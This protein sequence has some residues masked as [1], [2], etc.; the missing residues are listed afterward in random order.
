[1][2]L[3]KQETSL[4]NG[5][6]IPPQAVLTPADARRLQAEAKALVSEFQEKLQQT[7]HLFKLKAAKQVAHELPNIAGKLL[8]QFTSEYQKLANET[9]E[10]LRRDLQTAGQETSQALSKQLAEIREGALNGFLAE[11]MA[12]LEK[13]L[14]E[15]AGLLQEQSQALAQNANAALRSVEAAAGEASDRLQ[16]AR[17]QVESSLLSEHKRHLEELAASGRNADAAVRS[18][19]AATAE[20]AAKLQ[21]AREEIESSIVSDH[22]KRLEELAASGRNADTVIRLIEAATAEATAK[23]QSAREQMAAS[24]LADQQKYA[25]ELAVSSGNADTAMRAVQDAS[26]EA[27]AKLWAAGEQMESSLAS[28]YKKRAEELA[29]ASLNDLAHKA[30]ISV[31]GF[32]AQLEGA[33]SAFKRKATARIDEDIAKATAGLLERSAGQL[34]QQTDEVREKLLADLRDSGSGVLEDTRRQLKKIEKATSEILNEAAR[35]AAEKAVSQAARSVEDQAQ[36]AIS[37]SAELAI[38]K[39]TA[40]QKTLQTQAELGV[41]DHQRQLAAVSLA[42]VEGAQRALDKHLEVFWSQLQRQTDE[43]REKLLT[44]LTESGSVVLEDTRRQ[45]GKLEKASSEILQESARSAAEEAVG[46]AAKKA[47]EQAQGAIS[48]GAELAISKITAAQKTLQTQAELGVTDH[49]RQLAAVSL[50]S[51]EGAQRALDKHLEVFWS[52]LQRQT[53]EKR[54]KLLTDLTESGSS[55]LEDTRRQLGKLE[56]A[57]SEVLQEGAR[58]AAE[59][60]VGQAA[61]KAEEQAQGAISRSI[62]LAISKINAGEKDLKTQV[63]LRVADFQKLSVAVSESALESAQRKLD[64][65]LEIFHGQLEAAAGTIEQ[66]V[67]DKSRQDFPRVAAELVETTAAGMEKKADLMVRQI[68]EKIQASGSNLAEKA[69]RQA[70]TEAENSLRSMR[71]SAIEQTRGQ[72]QQLFKEMAAASRAQ[73]DTEIEQS[74][75][76][77]RKSVQAQ[78]EEMSRVSIEHLRSAA[79]QVG[80]APAPA[81]RAR[82]FMLVLVALIPTVLFLYLANRPVMRLTPNAPADFVEAYPELTS[83]HADTAQKLAQTYWD[84]AAVHLTADYPYGSQLPEQPPALFDAEGPSFPTGVEADVA[85]TRYWQKLRQLWSDPQSWQKIQVWNQ[86]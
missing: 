46:Q 85:R 3:Q 33:L 43:K 39:I 34:Q 21:A 78:I 55:V 77:Q 2:A 8:E 25:A 84:W 57:S 38:S 72:M 64:S 24:L 15:S 13:T 68:E 47:E 14:S 44:D 29:A 83:A 31:D 9:A 19:E 54:E 53:D 80:A 11:G 62:E 76:K 82:T 35:A 63:E 18:I 81:S 20:A 36:V 4:S 69:C 51:V 42:S 6:G 7:L 60:A 28:E 37:R 5:N 56:K 61:K 71:E 41:T 27:A 86:H 48:R 26:R 40:A 22:K 74:I 52:Q 12:S 10:Q 75:R 23:L 65:R 17:E 73:F 58:A 30:Q 50:A 66:I 70:S 16:A 32:E 59:K 49:Q 1:M 79:P 45:L 67:L